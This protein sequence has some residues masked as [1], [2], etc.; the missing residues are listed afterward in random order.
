MPCIKIS[1]LKC[2]TCHGVSIFT[3]QSSKFRKV[4]CKVELRCKPRISILICSV[5]SVDTAL[6][7]RN[8]VGAQSEQY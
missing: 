6:A 2:S 5:S 7:Q 3:D 8:G 1:K 4:L